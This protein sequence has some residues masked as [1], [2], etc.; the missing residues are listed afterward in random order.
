MA[1]KKEYDPFSQ[2]PRQSGETFTLDENLAPALPAKQTERAI[3]GAL[4]PITESQRARTR[5]HDDKA[6]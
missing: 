6:S 2:P 5:R 1:P 4:R 3:R